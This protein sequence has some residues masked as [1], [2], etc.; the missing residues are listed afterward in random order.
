MHIYCDMR[1]VVT[2]KWWYWHSTASGF[3]TT[4]NVQH[5]PSWEGLQ[6]HARVC[7][8][9][10][11]TSNCAERCLVPASSAPGKPRAT[12]GG[13]HGLPR[14]PSTRPRVSHPPN[15]SRPTEG[16]G[17]PSPAPAE[18]VE[19]LGELVKD[20]QEG[21]TGGSG[22]G[23]GEPGNPR[24]PVAAQMGRDKGRG[25][26]ARK[27]EGGDAASWA[28]ALCQYCDAH[29]PQLY[30]GSGEGGSPLRGR[31]HRGR[32][33]LGGGRGKVPKSLGGG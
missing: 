2:R 10:A 5:S 22:D 25:G 9:S 4:S 8:A 27:L 12:H 14:W 6:G 13:S 15:P 19:A 24:Q 7:Q 32:L 26:D 31:A 33:R 1:P 11:T 23:W 16:G 30:P 29:P 3:S 18:A 17:G 20:R 28:V 21:K